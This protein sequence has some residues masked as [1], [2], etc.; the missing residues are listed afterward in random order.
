MLAH[1]DTEPEWTLLTSRRRG[2]R[3]GGRSRRAGAVADGTRG[4][5]SRIPRAGGGGSAR[6]SQA[7]TSAHAWLSG[8]GPYSIVVKISQARDS[9]RVA[10]IARADRSAEDGG[11]RSKGSERGAGPRSGRGGAPVR[12]R[13]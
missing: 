5:N 3:P 13:L 12:P 9:T 7:L 6:A 8:A 11:S 1:A 10:A 4:S 2:R